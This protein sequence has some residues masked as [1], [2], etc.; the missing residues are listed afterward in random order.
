[1]FLRVN[2]I[3]QVPFETEVRH[4]QPLG[5]DDLLVAVFVRDEIIGV[6]SGDLLSVDVE[7]DFNLPA[8]LRDLSGFE[9]VFQIETVVAL[10]F[11]VVALGAELQVLF[12]II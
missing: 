12:E 3:Q 6:V 1:M 2:R 11:G 7:R 10:K 9:F 8:K 5:F 4:A